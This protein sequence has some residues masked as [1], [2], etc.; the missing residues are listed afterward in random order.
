MFENWAL[1]N[2]SRAKRDEVTGDGECCK[3]GTS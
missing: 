2:I 1:I 3:V